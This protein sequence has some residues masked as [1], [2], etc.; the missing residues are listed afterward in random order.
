MRWQLGRV[1]FI[2]VCVPSFQDR[3]DH[4]QILGLGIKILK[5][6]CHHFSG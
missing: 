4:I 5:I 2:I 6:A 3:F 1:D